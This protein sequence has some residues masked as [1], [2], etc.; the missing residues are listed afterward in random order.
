MTW[1]RRTRPTPPPTG[2]CIADVLTASAWGLTPEQWAALTDFE[3]AE[4]RRT[5]T[6]APRFQGQKT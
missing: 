1:F 4:A 3:R 5:I 2:Q 6:T